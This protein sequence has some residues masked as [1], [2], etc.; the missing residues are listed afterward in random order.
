[1][2]PGKGRGLRG[3]PGGRVFQA[4]S[5][6]GDKSPVARQGGSCMRKQDRAPSQDTAEDKAGW[7]LV[8]HTWR[9]SFKCR[10]YCAS[11]QRNIF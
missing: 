10:V 9:A 4:G 8:W 11:G 2:R 7:N 3:E 6:A 1:M 5:T